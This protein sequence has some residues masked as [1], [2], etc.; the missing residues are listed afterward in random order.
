MG[1]KPI[2]IGSSAPGG[3]ETSTA[4]RTVEFRSLAGRRASRPVLTHIAGHRAVY[5]RVECATLG[6]H[7][8]EQ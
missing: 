3:W 7:A 2:G 6:L 4:R 1:D 8:L 5:R